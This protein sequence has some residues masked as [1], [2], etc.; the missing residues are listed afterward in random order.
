M[1]HSGP[2]NASRGTTGPSEFFV[3]CAQGKVDPGKE[4]QGAQAA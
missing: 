1:S 4:R 2:V 3:P